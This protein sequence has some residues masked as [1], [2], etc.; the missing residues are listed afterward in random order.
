MHLNLP[1]NNV[2]LFKQYNTNNLT[3]WSMVHSLDVKFL[4]K[5]FYKLCAIA[6]H[7]LRLCC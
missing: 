1:F 7:I 2:T 6:D 5:L 4:E 3:A